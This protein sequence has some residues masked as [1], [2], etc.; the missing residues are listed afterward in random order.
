[1]GTSIASTL[2]S[3]SSQKALRLANVYLEKAY[4]ESDPEIVQELCRETEL[5]LTQAK[6]IA[7]CDNDQVMMDEIGATFIKLSQ[8]L[9]E[10]GCVH[11]AD[12]IRKKGEKLVKVSRPNGIA[13]VQKGTSHSVERAQASG[14]TYSSFQ[15]FEAFN[16]SAVVSA[17]IFAE[18]VN[19]PVRAFKLPGPDE[20]LHDTVQLAGCLDLLQATLMPGDKLEPAAHGWLQAIE[21]DTEE[22]DRLRTLATEVVRV[23]NRDELK[24]AKAVA[25]VVYLAPV[26]SKDNFQDLLSGFYSRIDHSGLLKIYQLEG[27][28]HLIQCAHPGY[29]DGDDLVRIFGLLSSRLQETHGQSSHHMHKLTL[30]VSH[31]LDTMVDTKVKNIEMTK[32][33]EPF[34]LYLGELTKSTDPYMV[35]QAAYAFQALLCIPDNETKWQSA[36]RRTGNVSRGLSRIVSAVKGLDLGKLIEGLRKLQGFGGISN[37]VD[38]TMTPYDKVTT[39]TQSGQGFMESLR[40]GLSF[41][42]KRDWYAALRGADVLIRDGEL[43]TFRELVCSAPCRLDPAF[44]WGVCQRL[45][46]IAA[47]QTWDSDIRRS[48][49][50]FLGEIYKEDI[51]WVHTAAAEA[52]LEELETN[53]DEK[54]RDLYQGCRQ[55]GSASYPLKIALPE[56]ASPSLLDRVQSRPDIDGNIRLLKKQRIKGRSNKVYVPPQ[57]RSRIQENEETRFPLM[58]NVKEFL[59]SDRKVFLLHGDSG[60]GKLTFINELEYD[61]WL[62]YRN[63]ADRIPLFINLPTIDKPEQDMIVKH[64]RKAEF[65]EPQIRE[66]KHHR[67]FILIC[68]GYDES[69]QTH[70]LYMSNRLNQPGEWDAKMVISCGT[71]YLGADYRDCFLPKDRNQQPD[72][73]QFQ[74]AI[75]TPFTLGMVHAYIHQYVAI[76]QPLWRR[77]DYQQALGLIPGLKDLVTN[78]FMMTLTLDVLPRMVDPG[79]H[80]S[81]VHVTRLGLYD[82]FV[83]QWLERGKKRLEEKDM[84]PQARE[85]FERLT[86]EGFTVNGIG[87][88]KKF[89]IAIY[90]EQGGQPVVEYSQLVDE[91]SWKDE[92]FKSRDKQLLYEA[93]PLTRSGNQH[94]FIHRSLLEYAM[95]RAIYDPEDRRNKTL[96]ELSSSRRGSTSSILSFEIEDDSIQMLTS[97]KE[98][99]FNSPLVWRS[100]VNDH[101]LLQFLEEKVK[102]EPL[103]KAQ[104]LQYIEHSKTDMKWRKA[105]AN[106]ITILVRAGVQFIGADL[107]GIRIPGADLSFGIFDSAQLQDA[108]LRKVNLEYVAMR[109]ADLRRA[110]MTGV[111]FGEMPF[112]SEDSEIHSCA[113]SPDGATLAVGGFESG[114]QLYSTSTYQRIRRSSF[115]ETVQCVVYSPQSDRIATCNLDEVKIRN[116]ETDLLFTLKGHTDKVN[117]VAFSPVGGRIASG[118]DDGTVRLWSLWSDGGFCLRIYSGYGS[119]ILCLAYS[120]NDRQIAS[121]GAGCT[122]WLWNTGISGDCIRILSGHSG[123]VLAVKYSPRGDQ[124][125]SASEDA[126][127][128]LWDMDSG[129]C[130]HILTGHVGP[131]ISVAFSPKGDQVATGS[132][133]R[134]VKLWDIETGHCRQTLTGHT[135]VVTGVVY[136]PKGDQ[137]ASVSKDRS[138]RLCSVSSRFVSSNHCA[139]VYGVKCSPRGGS[140]ASC[141]LDGT[142]RFWDRTTGELSRTLK[143]HRDAVFGIDFSSRGDWI[144]SGGADMTV[145]IWDVDSGACYQILIGHTEY[146]M[147]VAFSPYD[148]TIAS[149]SR[150]KTIRVWDT[151]TGERRWIWTGNSAM[152]SVVI[153]PDG[154][155]VASGSSSAVRIWDLDTGDSYRAKGEFAGSALG[156]V[157]SPRGTRLAS[158]GH[159]QTIHLW[160]ANSGDHLFALK[161]HTGTVRCV[162]YSPEGDL[163]ASG[164]YDRTVRIWDLES[165]AALAVVEDFQS[166]VYSVAWDPMSDD[167]DNCLVTGSGDGSVLKW[168][169]NKSGG[170]VQLLWSSTNGT[171][172][173]TGA[174]VEGV[175]GLSPVNQQLLEQRGAIMEPHEHA[176]VVK[177]EKQEPVVKHEKQEPDHH[178][179]SSL[180]CFLGIE[181]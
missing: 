171:L 159:D 131:V 97:G 172:D 105:A 64:L 120:P 169:V 102:Q 165:G 168:N 153:S 98:P 41:N 135:D 78:P 139:E 21:K 163:L 111:Q 2:E 126:T 160:S 150:D 137:I 27:L 14:A 146:V 124:V 29:I 87:Y 113:Y 46:E 119:A 142:I 107:R 121:G 59:D 50:A 56:F 66:M 145:R 36:M 57:A 28:A 67:K 174:L 9:K 16:S 5:S 1:M 158:V 89:A 45:G 10:Q 157:Y 123:A 116:A 34:S 161:G 179:I 93:C 63:K 141:G 133:D 17:H 19:P 47:N 132:A 60:A 20:R 108:D 76:H 118:S 112:L 80:L 77:E 104:L 53:G 52:Q 12:A 175:R 83:E 166:P 156:V 86:A 65:T 140:I 177:Q 71:E 23:F 85:E 101:S 26:L 13:Q 130:R 143:G 49:I 48:A 90:K 74:E 127:V 30:A 151:T 176:P 170:D 144:V 79:Q 103:F 155:Q 39:L 128:R 181:R 136:S 180:L 54:K 70:N 42:Q 110:Q 3:L 96:A 8:L 62:S 7:K 22:Q 88:I 31:V 114:I 100:F 154:T 58:E 35:Y 15:G 125:A 24:D 81:T 82:H 92:F 75:I 129:A 18:N 44:Q 91:G 106:A 25:E 173:V 122:V 69:R 147:A 178:G 61:L 94:R 99:D 149:A 72:P 4:G 152:M 162:A 117:C 40:E 11:E 115:R 51:V 134:M 6:R 138:I 68:D 38:I 95:A 148:D 164:G 37:F 84:A 73:S 33:H 109:K 55:Q 43:A 32:L 167:G